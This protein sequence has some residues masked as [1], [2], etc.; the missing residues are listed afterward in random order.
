MVPA[1]GWG[2]V[3][4]VKVPTGPA[5]TRVGADSPLV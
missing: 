4:S 2:S 5:S 1:W 3:F